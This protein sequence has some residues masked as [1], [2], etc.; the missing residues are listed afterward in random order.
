M[1]FSDKMKEMLAGKHF[2]GSEQ[3]ITKVLQNQF[4]YFCIPK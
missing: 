2:A 1:V 4:S 3:L